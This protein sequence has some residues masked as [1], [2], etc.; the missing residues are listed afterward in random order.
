MYICGSVQQVCSKQQVQVLAWCRHVPF[1]GG[2]GYLSLDGRGDCGSFSRVHQLQPAHHA[3][4]VRTFVQA[5]CCDNSVSC[6]VV[7]ISFVWGVY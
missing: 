3:Y 4:S 1:G 7:S 6:A 2:Q 5:W